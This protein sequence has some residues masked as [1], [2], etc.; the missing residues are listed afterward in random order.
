[1]Y[2]TN[3]SDAGRRLGEQLLKYKGKKC[4]IVALSDGA[5]V[6]AAQIAQMLKCPITMLLAEQ[7]LAPG[8]PEAVGSINQD[9]GYSY[10][11]AYSQGQQDEFNMEYHHMFE[12]QKLEKLSQMHRLLG[13]NELI[14]K[15]ML[16]GHTVILVADGLGSVASIDAAVLFL[17]AIKIKKLII[18][19]PFASVNVVDRMHILGDDIA[20]L[21]VVQNFMGT[22][23]Y[24]E[25]NAI[26]D[27]GMIIATIQEM[28]RE[29]VL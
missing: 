13:T 14:R 20:C 16:R 7:I 23:H 17:K 27:H 24:Y 19:T 3:R 22:D 5:V 15:D 18:A 12:Q 11:S 25:D 9:G 8:E 29:W 26:P 6:V 2:F 21:S 4:T 1:M 28:V 10:N